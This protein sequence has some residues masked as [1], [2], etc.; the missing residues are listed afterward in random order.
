MFGEK[1][2]SSDLSVW[3]KTFSQKA[4]QRFEARRHW[5]S[6]YQLQHLSRSSECENGKSTENIHNDLQA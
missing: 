6:T 5:T 1:E 2:L 4:K 3:K